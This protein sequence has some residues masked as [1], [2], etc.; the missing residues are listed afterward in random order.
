MIKERGKAAEMSL[1]TTVCLGIALVVSGLLSGSMSI[2]AEEENPEATSNMPAQVQ[3]GEPMRPAAAKLRDLEQKASE[4]DFAV[5]RSE[6]L[7]QDVGKLRTALMAAQ[8]Q[9]EEIRSRMSPGRIMDL[10]KKSLAYGYLKEQVAAQNK[11]IGEIERQLAE[12]KCVTTLMAEENEK[13]KQSMAGQGKNEDGLKQEID[14][15]KD[16]VAQLQLGNYEFYEVKDGDTLASIAADPL[17]YGDSSQAE[18]I[19][20]WNVNRVKDI[21]NLKPHEVLFI[22][23]FKT[24]GRFDW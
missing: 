3:A 22:P 24:P 6:A 14:A 9:L 5:R 17:I 21:N 1:K 23:R 18:R 12:E 2:R 4:H 13:L 11:R 10:E 8:T 15:L 19:R 16:V 20:Q 7:Q